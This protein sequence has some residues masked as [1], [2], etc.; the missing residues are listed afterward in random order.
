MNIA[1]FEL[2]DFSFRDCGELPALET[3]GPT[4]L[5]FFR[6]F[7]LRSDQ[8]ISRFHRN[9]VPNLLWAQVAEAVVKFNDILKGVQKIYQ[10]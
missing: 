8:R 6:F 5:Y 10:N 7:F 2:F 1:L 4:S 3:S 9:G